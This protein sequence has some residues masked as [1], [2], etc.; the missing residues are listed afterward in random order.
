MEHGC[1]ILNKSIFIQGICCRGNEIALPHYHFFFFPFFEAAQVLAWISCYH[2]EGAYYQL[3][4]SSLER[5][6]LE[7]WQFGGSLAG[8]PRIH[9]KFLGHIVLNLSVNRLS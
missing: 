1:S 4:S 7:V 2:G 9:S 8:L 5:P 3:S 6:C